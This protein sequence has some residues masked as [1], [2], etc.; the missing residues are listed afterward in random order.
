MILASSSVVKSSKLSF[1]AV[2]ESGEMKRGFKFC[3]EFMLELSFEFVFDCV[4]E[5][6]FEFCVE[7]AFR[8]DFALEFGFKFEFVFGFMFEFALLFTLIFFECKMFDF[9]SPCE[10][11]LFAVSFDIFLP[12]KFCSCE[13]ETLEFLSFKLLSFFVI[14]DFATFL[15]KFLS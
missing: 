7:L 5:F 2:F 8:F 9:L 13:F 11:D 15:A 12:F 6:T 1:W 3:F 10:F 14:L 4:S